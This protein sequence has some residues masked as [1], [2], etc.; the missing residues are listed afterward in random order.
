MKALA[1]VATYI[2]YKDFKEDTAND[3]ACKASN[4]FNASEN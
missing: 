2:G 1:T 3:V 4:E